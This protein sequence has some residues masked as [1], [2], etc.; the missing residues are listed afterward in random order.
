[1][2]EITNMSEQQQPPPNYYETVTGDMFR[3]LSA[4]RVFVWTVKRFWLV[5]V[6]I[7]LIVWTIGFSI[8]WGVDKNGNRNDT[9][10]EIDMI[11]IEH[12][13]DVKLED[14]SFLM[15]TI[16]RTC[17]SSPSC[18]QNSHCVVI[19]DINDEAVI[20]ETQCKCDEGFSEEGETCVDVDECA[21]SGQHRCHATAS[22]I[23]KQGSHEC[24]CE[25]GFEL[26]LIEDKLGCVD[27]DECKYPVTTCRSIAAI[28]TNTIGSYECQCM[29]GF[30]KDETRDDPC[31]DI[32]ESTS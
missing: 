9:L 10:T 17:D 31:P 2:I 27:K 5:I 4:P 13:L 19:A 28:C 14:D 24:T 25:E 15:S 21:G 3:Q 8:G 20:F 7:G 29:T 30:E 11:K 18:G 23:N 16:R 6:L 22:C 26:E 32:G 12:L 1:M